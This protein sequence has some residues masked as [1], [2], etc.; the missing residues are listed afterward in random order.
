MSATGGGG[1]G[2]EVGGRHCLQA[3]ERVGERTGREC[4]HPSLAH[5]LPL[6]PPVQLIEL[7][8]SC[9]DLDQEQRAFLC[10]LRE[11]FDGRP[12]PPVLLLAL[13]GADCEDLNI[14]RCHSGRAV[15][16]VDLLLRSVCVG[17]WAGGVVGLG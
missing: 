5:L 17:G 6:K 9:L 1:L 14:R 3:G 7:V 13:L 10:P 4:A 11:V 15:L 12:M 16:V 8:R 2:G